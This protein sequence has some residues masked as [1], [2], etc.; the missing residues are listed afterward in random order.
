MAE[1][2]TLNTVGNLQDTTTAQTVLNANNALIETAFSDVLS[3]SGVSPNQMQSNL[4]MNSNQILNLPAP[5]TINSPVRLGDVI[6][7]STAITIPPVGTSGAVVG[8]LNGNNAYSG[9]SRF[10][11][12]VKQIGPFVTTGSTTV[13]FFNNS[14]GNSGQVLA[15]SGSSSSPTWITVRDNLTTNASFYVSTTGNDVNN[16]SSSS[17]WRTIQH[18]V[19]WIASNVDMAGNSIGLNIGSGTFAGFASDQGAWLGNT[20]IGISGAG[21][22]ST[23]IQCLPSGNAIFAKDLS[24]ITIS[25]VTIEDNG[26]SNGVGGV[27]CGQGCV[28]DIG[29][30]VKFGTIAN[31]VHI[32]AANGGVINILSTYTI[33]GNAIQ[34]ISTAFGG[35]ITYN[36]IT[37]FSIPSALS[38]SIFANAVYQGNI[39]VSGASTFTGSGVAGT[40]GTK[41][42]I[43]AG[44]CLAGSGG[45]DFN[46]IFPGTTNGAYVLA[47][48]TD[49]TTGGTSTSAT[50]VSPSITTPTI[51]G[52]VSGAITFAT[53][54][55][56]LVYTVTTLNAIS[57]PAT[58][59]RA[60]VTDATGTT[61]GAVVSG[62]STFVTPVYYNG[63]WRIG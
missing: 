40:T 30:D 2:V 4:D 19:T 39:Q 42:N 10:T 52:T 17:P 49:F 11:G 5:A 35:L 6:S 12:V 28:L 20:E 43:A 57:S 44:G 46:S 47:P 50:I 48:P 60:I 54:P 13:Y 61:F 45:T 26:S 16:G 53:P 56:T 8:L 18:A 14:A 29:A 21:S 58:G 63:S 37:G 36:G 51:T 27:V 9:T 59:M 1:N 55:A 24:I 7:A 41:F 38:F 15:S 25:G 34:H 3:L 23:F 32:S 33:T 62:G 22:A 31:G